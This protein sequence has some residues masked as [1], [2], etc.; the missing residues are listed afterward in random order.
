MVKEIKMSQEEIEKIK[1]ER[2]EYLELSKR[3]K[4]EAVNEKK[5]FDSK[6]FRAQSVGYAECVMSIIPALDSIDLALSSKT[7]DE[8]WSLGVNLALKQLQ[9]SLNAGGVEFFKP[10]GETYDPKK[11]NSVEAV[12]VEE[13]EVN[14]IISIVRSGVSFNG[15]VVR[16]ADV[17]V[18]ISK[19]NLEKNN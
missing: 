1:K 2:D 8:N 7:K 13:N 11:H 6:V 4:A 12:E 14:K 15:V 17:K 19:S 18:G 9:E 5:D 10:E 3:L 16:P